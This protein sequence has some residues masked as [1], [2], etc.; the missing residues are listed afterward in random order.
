MN[1]LNYYKRSIFSAV[2]IYFWDAFEIDDFTE[3]IFEID[4]FTTFQP[5]TLNMHK[6]GVSPMVYKRDKGLM[7]TFRVLSTNL[8]ARGNEFVSTVEGIR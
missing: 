2:H 1:Q 6:M 5:V 3:H 8:D 4:D 7:N